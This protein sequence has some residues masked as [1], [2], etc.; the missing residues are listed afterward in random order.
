M[1]IICYKIKK[2]KDRILVFLYPRQKIACQNT[3]THTAESSR[4]KN[5]QDSRAYIY[6][7][8]RQ[9]LHVSKRG[10]KKK[11]KV[12]EI[13]SAHWESSTFSTEPGKSREHK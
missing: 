6:M 12:L 13:Y 3:H 9:M 11:K 5:K 7:Y 1:S 10:R 2:K 8:S 4:K